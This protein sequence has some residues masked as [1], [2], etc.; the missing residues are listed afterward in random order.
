MIGVVVGGGGVCVVVVAVAVV[1][2]GVFGACHI[3]FP[4]D[5]FC[6]KFVLSLFSLLF[7]TLFP[8]P[9]DWFVLSRTT[10][11]QVLSLSFSLS[12]SLSLF[13]YSLH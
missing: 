4:C 10:V 1:G 8:F 6:V 7:P 2:V 11:F 3:P 9:Q 12:L 5:L 13:L